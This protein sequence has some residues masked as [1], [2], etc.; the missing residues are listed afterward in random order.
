MRKTSELIWQ[1]TQ[2][3]KLF[4]ILDLLRRPGAGREVLCRL[5]AYTEYHFELEEQYMLLLDFPGRDQHIETHNR[6]REE[7]G[8]LVQDEQELDAQFQEIIATFL[9]EWLTR[10]VFGI[11]KELEAFIL[12]SEAK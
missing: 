4:Q 5:E 8:K 10:H 2:H 6:F 9:T 3:Q 1:D 11:D 7:I 12:D